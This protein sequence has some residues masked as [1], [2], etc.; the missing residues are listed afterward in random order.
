MPT[1]ARGS[2]R[3]LEKAGRGL[4]AKARQPKGSIG[5]IRARR[6]PRRAV[7]DIGGVQNRVRPKRGWSVARDEVGSSQ[8][9]DRACRSFSDAVQ[10]VYVRRTG[11]CVNAIYG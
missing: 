8:L 5:M 11:R 6:R 3:V 9:H 7:Q 10:L 1:Q 2:I 4:T